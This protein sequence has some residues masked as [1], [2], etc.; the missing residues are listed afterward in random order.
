MSN[1]SRGNK[2]EDEKKLKNIKYFLCNIPSG[3]SG[4]CNAASKQKL[5]MK[6]EKENNLI[7]LI[8][9]LSS[10]IINVIVI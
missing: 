10:R 5:N 4:F 6:I 2:Y 1:F 7:I 3:I 8:R 9:S